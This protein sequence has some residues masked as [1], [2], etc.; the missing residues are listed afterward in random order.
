MDTYGILLIAAGFLACLV[1]VVVYV[2]SV[3]WPKRRGGRHLM[4]FTGAMGALFGQSL[5]LRI[6]GPFPGSDFVNLGIVT[7][8]VLLLWDRVRLLVTEQ[9]R[10]NSEP[11]ER[12]GD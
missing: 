9:Y 3:G 6:L 11:S 1:F 8:I 2:S 4:V 10:R 12:V 7:L 5:A